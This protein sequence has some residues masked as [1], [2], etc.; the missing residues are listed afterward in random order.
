MI[1]NIVQPVIPI[2]EVLSVFLYRRANVNIAPVIPITIVDT[3]LISIALRF[4]TSSSASL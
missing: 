3:N 4:N 2:P 1:M